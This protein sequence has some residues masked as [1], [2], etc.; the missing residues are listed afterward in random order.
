MEQQSLLNGAGATPAPATD[1]VGQPVGEPQPDTTVKPAQELVTAPSQELAETATE[2]CWG[3]SEEIIT[4]DLEIPKIHL[5]QGQSSFVKNGHCHPG[6]FVDT[7]DKGI[8]AKNSAADL[9][10]R[11]NLEIIIFG[12]EKAWAVLRLEP[13]TNPNEQDN[14]KFVKMEQFDPLHPDREF[15]PLI[16]GV[17]HKNVLVYNYRCL[18]ADQVKKD[19]DAALPY[20]LSMRNSARRP[21]KQIAVLIQKM[22]M[23]NKP[24]ASYIFKIG[25]EEKAVEGNQGTYFVP[26]VGLGRATTKKEMDTAFKWYQLMKTA[27]YKVDHSD[28]AEEGGGRPAPT[29]RPPQ[30]NFTQENVPF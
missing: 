21:A 22:S 18:V 1:S 10:K 7:L 11:E 26:E 28:L 8:L 3:A 30:G 23:R 25:R 17:P 9:A 29:H 19:G 12:L 14:Y 5:A 16:D 24:S 2:G 4:Q 13:K 15:M 20:I 6:D 27:G